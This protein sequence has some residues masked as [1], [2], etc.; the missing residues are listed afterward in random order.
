LGIRLENDILI[1][2]NGNVDLCSNIPLEREEIETL[3]R[4]QGEKK[5]QG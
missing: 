5:S 2:E 3:M 4:A 1:T